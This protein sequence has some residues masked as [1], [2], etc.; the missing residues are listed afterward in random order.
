MD[1]IH[2]SRFITKTV[3]EIAHSLVSANFVITRF[4]QKRRF[5]CPNLPSISIL[6]SSSCRAS[7]LAASSSARFSSVT[8][9]GR[10]RRAPDNLI[11]EEAGLELKAQ[12]NKDLVE[13]ENILKR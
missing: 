3:I 10:P 12:K 11:L 8:F 9:G 1:F 7:S 4:M 6:S 2:F 13:I 5:A